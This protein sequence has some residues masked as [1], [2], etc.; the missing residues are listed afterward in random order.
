MG[1]EETRT[2]PHCNRELE[3]ETR[4]SGGDLM[5]L[6]SC[7]CGWAAARTAFGRTRTTSGVVRRGGSPKDAAN[8]NGTED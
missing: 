2:C 7:E 4:E 3:R 8:N 1:D 5:Y 6:W